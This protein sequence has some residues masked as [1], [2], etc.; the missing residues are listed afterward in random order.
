MCSRDDNPTTDQTPSDQTQADVQPDCTNRRRSERRRRKAAVLPE[1]A[2]MSLEG[3][4]SRAI[5]EKFEIPR[6]TIDHWL[7]AQRRAW[8]VQTSENTR[9]I[10]AVTLARLESAYCEAM[11]A[12][13]QSLAEN[14]ARIVADAATDEDGAQPKRS[15]RTAGR[16]APAALLGKAIEAALAIHKLKGHDAPG[17]P[18]DITDLILADFQNL[19]DAQLDALEEKYLVKEAHAHHMTV[20]E[21]RASCRL[22]RATRGNAP[23]ERTEEQ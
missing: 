17:R 5:A 3:Y 20:E 1:I 4:S 16:A 12:W 11:K 23:A 6:R 15:T 19:T 14:Q 22:H 13:R 8:T 7:H 18:A 21:Y 10:F 2:Q 9:E